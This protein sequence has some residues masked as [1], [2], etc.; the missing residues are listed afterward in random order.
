MTPEE[1]VQTLAT[2]VGNIPNPKL[3]EI[4]LKKCSQ[5]VLPLKDTKK[6]AVVQELFKDM[7]GP[8]IHLLEV[9]SS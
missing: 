3:Q 2:E 8:V 6:E 4:M 1:I 5:E 7:I 9:W